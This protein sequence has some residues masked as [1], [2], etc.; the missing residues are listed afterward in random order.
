MIL[1]WNIGQEKERVRGIR[2]RKS[3]RALRDRKGR[4]GREG[5]SQ[6]GE[7]QGGKGTKSKIEKT[8]WGEVE[9]HT[10]RKIM[11]EKTGQKS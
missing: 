7:M 5:E 6:E 3:E 2:Q 10:E 4:K 1:N 8:G 11:K 9:R